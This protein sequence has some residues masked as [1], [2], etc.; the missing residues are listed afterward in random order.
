[1]TKGNYRKN[2]IWRVIVSKVFPELA[3]IRQCCSKL[4]LET[5]IIFKKF[6]FRFMNFAK[7]KSV[8]VPQCALVQPANLWQSDN[9]EFEKKGGT[10]NKLP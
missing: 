4:Q 9:A 2:L 10:I 1:M 7:L 8:P 3:D 5:P 6:Y